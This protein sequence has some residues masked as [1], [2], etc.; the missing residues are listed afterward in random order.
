M[1]DRIIFMGAPVND[2]VANVIQAQL[3]FL[4]SVDARRDKRAGS[5]TYC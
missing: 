4:D 2:Y 3:L 5:V 1:M